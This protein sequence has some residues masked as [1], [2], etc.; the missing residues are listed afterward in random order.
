M[1]MI[2]LI[3]TSLLINAFI[4]HLW[5]YVCETLMPLK[6]TSKETVILA[7]KSMSFKKVSLERFLWLSQ[8]TK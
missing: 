5:K 3:I 1:D 6:A 4:I 2:I 8:Y 7:H